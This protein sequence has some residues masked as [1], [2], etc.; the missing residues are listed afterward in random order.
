MSD[1]AITAI[2]ILGFGLLIACIAFV[3]VAGV[4][5]GLRIHRI[6][7]DKDPQQKHGIE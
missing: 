2:V 3:V 5:N 4:K 7:K 6:L 1:A